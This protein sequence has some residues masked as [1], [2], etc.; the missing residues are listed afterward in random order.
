M[1]TQMILHKCYKPATTIDV[2]LFCYINSFNTYY[3]FTDLMI[4]LEL[5][6]FEIIKFFEINGYQL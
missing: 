1:G 6:G 5:V 4:R 3:Q 2:I